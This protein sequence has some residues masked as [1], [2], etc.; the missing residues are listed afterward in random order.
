MK[1]LFVPLRSS[2]SFLNVAS[3]KSIT[4]SVASVDYVLLYSVVSTVECCTAFFVIVE[5]VYLVDDRWHHLLYSS[6]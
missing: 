3:G 1:P 6:M 5:N 2:S 4:A